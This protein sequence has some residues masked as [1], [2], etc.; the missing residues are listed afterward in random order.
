MRSRIHWDTDP[1]CAAFGD[2]RVGHG[3]PGVKPGAFLLGPRLFLR[4][5]REDHGPNDYVWVLIWVVG[6]ELPGLTGGRFAL[7]SRAKGRG[8]ALRCW[9]P[10]MGPRS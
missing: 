9:G 4:S 1:G 7:G 5:R 6:P 10:D 8:A 2:P 3:D